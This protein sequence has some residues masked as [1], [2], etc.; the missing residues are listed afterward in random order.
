MHDFHYFDRVKFVG[1]HAEEL[2]AKGL[3]TTGVV[4]VSL[5]GESDP[6]VEIELDIVENSGQGGGSST[7]LYP[8]SWSIT[9][10]PIELSEL[11]LRLRR[12]ER[13]RRW[14]NEQNARP[15]EERN[16]SIVAR[17]EAFLKEHDR[18]QKVPLF[19]W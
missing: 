1:R 11:G 4:D 9:G 6:F 10:K 12:I 14:L 18:G 13:Y 5:Y 19:F 16:T 8:P 7:R 2:R 3:C 15:T 17:C